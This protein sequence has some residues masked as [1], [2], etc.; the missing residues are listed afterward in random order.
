M[1]G[2]N[3]RRSMVTKTDV[4]ELLQGRGRESYEQNHPSV[5]NVV[6]ERLMEERSVETYDDLYDMFTDAGY[7]LDFDAFYDYCQGEANL[8]HEEFVRGMVGVLELDEEEKLAFAW[9]IMWGQVSKA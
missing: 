3:G 5:F 6:L 4:D 9:A 2:I 1:T 8:I 7:E